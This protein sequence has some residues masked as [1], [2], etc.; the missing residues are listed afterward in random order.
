MH[1]DYP[2]G[3]VASFSVAVG[4]FNGDGKPDLVTANY[5]SGSVSV[6]L[7]NGDGTFAA[8]TDSRTGDNPSSV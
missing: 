6:L 7:G 5:E 4:D 3:D 2:I 1:T 8:K